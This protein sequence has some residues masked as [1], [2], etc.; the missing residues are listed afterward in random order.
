MKKITD[1]KERR[2]RTEYSKDKL[3]NRV[4]KTIPYIGPREVIVV[5]GGRRFAHFF[6]DLVVFECFYALFSYPQLIADSKH[7]DRISFDA[8]PIFN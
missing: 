2:F 7:F 1:L 5:Q 4:K 3:G 6:V 8:G